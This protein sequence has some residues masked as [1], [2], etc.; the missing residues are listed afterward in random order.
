MRPK[1][2]KQK[3]AVFFRRT[4]GLWCT[5]TFCSSSLFFQPRFSSLAG[6]KTTNIP[7]TTAFTRQKSLWGGRVFSA[8][9]TKKKIKAFSEASWRVWL[10][11][12]CTRG[13]RVPERRTCGESAC[14]QSSKGLFLQT[15]GTGRDWKTPPSDRTSALEQKIKA[16]QTTLMLLLSTDKVGQLGRCFGALWW[17]QTSASSKI[18]AQKPFFDRVRNNRSDVR[19]T[20]WCIGRPWGTSS[21]FVK[22]IRAKACLP[23]W[24]ITLQVSETKTNEHERLFYIADVHQF[25][26]NCQN[27]LFIPALPLDLKLDHQ[28]QDP[29]LVP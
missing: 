25:R 10:L 28:I 12:V 8:A 4:D 14:S 20:W 17:S 22:N 11:W 16:G 13:K 1:Q 23:L 6:D 3:L 7:I 19:L 18:P 15:E 27:C 21:F 5:V 24:S 26:S 29:F 9:G 2:L